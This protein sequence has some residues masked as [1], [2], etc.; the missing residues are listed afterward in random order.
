MEILPIM[1]SIRIPK[2]SCKKWS[3]RLN[4]K[5]L[6]IFTVIMTMMYCETARSNQR[7]PF[8]LGTVPIRSFTKELEMDKSLKEPGSVFSFFE[9]VRQI[10]HCTGQEPRA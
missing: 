10:I 7:S 8:G 2:R 9:S 5:L 3:I 4:P 1:L 6:Y